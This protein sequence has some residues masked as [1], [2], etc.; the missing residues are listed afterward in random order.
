MA[1]SD[2]ELLEFKMEATELLD[3]AEQSLLSLAEHTT[4]FEKVF[5][6]IFRCFHNL[7]GASGMMELVD[8]QDHVHELETLL[9]PFKTQTSIPPQ[10][11]DLFL[12]GIDGARQILSGK[13]ISF[14]YEELFETLKNVESSLFQKQGV[15]SELN[16]RKNSNEA[17]ESQ[18]KSPQSDPK[19]ASDEKEGDS[20]IRVSVGV[21]DSLMTLVGEM[22]LVRNQVLQFSNQTEN[23]DFLNLSKRLNVVTNEIQ[24]EVMK[25]RMQPI[26]N[27]FNKFNRVVRDLCKDLM[28]EISL[29]ISGA[30]TELDKTLLESIKDPLMHIVRN[31]CDHGIED[32]Q[33]RVSRSK[34]KCGNIW[35]KAHH[36]GGQVIL[37]VRDDGKGL[38]REVLIRKA[39][40]KGI[41]SASQGS[42]LTDQEAFNL[43]FSP[44]FS[45]AASI[46]SV[47]GRG[48]GMDVVRTNVDRIGGTVD[49][50]SLVGQGTTIKLKIP[51]T[52][53]IV[54]AL[55]VKCSGDTFA[56][57]QVKL[58]ELV[59]VDAASSGGKIELL[60]GVPVYRLRGN[61]LPLLSLN[62]I[63]KNGEPSCEVV[64]IAVVRSASLSF[65][66]IVDE[67]IDTGDIVV[68][69]LN[70]LLKHLQVYSGATIL[71]D[72]SVALI[73]DIVGISKKQGFGAEADEK[74]SSVSDQKADYKP[75]ESQDYLYVRLATP[76]LH[77]IMLNDVFR[78]EKFG[79]DRIENTKSGKVVRY[80]EHILP[81]ISLNDFFGYEAE[82]FDLDQVLV[83]VMEKSEHLYGLVVNEIVD[84]VSIEAPVFSGVAKVGGTYG[85]LN[86][87]DRIVTV[88]DSHDVI[89]NVIPGSS[90][91][92][93][94]NS[95]S[96]PKDV[97]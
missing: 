18:L 6:N 69:P 30:E 2:E 48:V 46:T 27:V 8:L 37:E 76:T 47:S 56:I 68:K 29:H 11:V 15:N 54:P 89:R 61:I 14:I 67:I 26:G 33:T 66:L 7:K 5:D 31:A 51:L 53:A 16:L 38:D 60:H 55:I 62:Q 36:E 72:G 96:Q 71:G 57:P 90:P 97:A 93:T 20:S 91:R 9:M 21:L 28:K 75:K 85:E 79:R 23:M 10:Y 1:F 95:V 58:E 40:E 19:V 39:V 32:Q 45:T 92:A 77:A 78:L 44:G 73:L 35:I 52:L 83:V 82:E 64:N 12:R 41:I 24:C 88:I 94:T 13:K 22:V 59:R 3:L 86:L 80:G 49:I 84:T 43:I 70:K 74:K 50:E 87:T 81:L 17:S 25:T 4:P 34:D 63:L 42:Q 65:G